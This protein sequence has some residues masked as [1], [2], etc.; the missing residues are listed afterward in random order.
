MQL[1]VLYASVDQTGFAETLKNTEQVIKKNGGGVDE[2]QDMKTEMVSRRKKI[3]ALGISI[4]PLRANGMLSLEDMNTVIDN[5]AKKKPKTRS[6]GKF[7]SITPDIK[8]NRFRC[9]PTYHFPNGQVKRVSVA[10]KTREAAEMAVL[11]K[12]RDLL[13]ENTNNAKGDYDM[14][15]TYI[16]NAMV[17]VENFKTVIKR[18]AMLDT[19]N[20]VIRQMNNQ[21]Q[22][23]ENKKRGI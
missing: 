15:I 16:Q 1:K 19:L 11:E 23:L 10:G 20:D 7:C 13:R 22:L 3:E 14:Q 5:M 2:I 8:N 12:L 6:K 9:N 18:Q 17:D 4:V 21:I